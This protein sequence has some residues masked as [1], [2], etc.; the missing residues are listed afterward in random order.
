MSVFI[1]SMLLVALPLWDIKRV[2]DMMPLLSLK[3]AQQLGCRL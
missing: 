3:S 2:L 1:I